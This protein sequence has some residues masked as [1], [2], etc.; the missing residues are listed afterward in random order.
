MSSPCSSPRSCHKSSCSADI[1]VGDSWPDWAMCWTRVAP[2]RWSEA[3]E[4]EET[5]VTRRVRECGRRLP[6]LWRDPGGL[7]SRHLSTERRRAFMKKLDTVEGSRPSWRAMVTCISLEG[8][9]V[10]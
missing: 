3:E 5:E 6:G 10:S 9:F 4:E 7:S 8:R 1:E 2:G